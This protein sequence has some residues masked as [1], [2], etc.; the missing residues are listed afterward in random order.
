MNRANFEKAA[1]DSMEIVYLKDENG[2]LI[3]GED[4]EP[5]LEGTAYVLLDTQAVMIKPPTQADYDQ[6]MSLYEAAE[7]ISG[8]DENIWAIVQECA[9]TLFAGDRT[10]EDAARM[11]Q[12]RVELYLNEQ[13]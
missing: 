5:L 9:G 6:V 3:T 10:A 12:N 8:R 11:I 13:K 2:N 4:G 7:G 1:Q